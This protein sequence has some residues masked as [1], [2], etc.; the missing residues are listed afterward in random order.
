LSYNN[1]KLDN[2]DIKGEN[3]HRFFSLRTGYGGG[4][5]W[6]WVEY[7]TGNVLIT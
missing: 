6:T 4:L 5:F 3:I 2:E 1:I 7:K